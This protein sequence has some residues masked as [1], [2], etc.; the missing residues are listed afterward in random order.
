MVFFVVKPVSSKIKQCRLRRDDFE[1]LSLIG[2]GAFG[3]V[4]E[5]FYCVKQLKLAILQ[6]LEF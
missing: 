4:R 2:K 5:P 3:E 1:P 6:R